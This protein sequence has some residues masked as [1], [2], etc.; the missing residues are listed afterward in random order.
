MLLTE[1]M[2]TV[3]RVAAAGGVAKERKT[4]LAV[5]SMP[6]VLLTSAKTT[7]G[8]VVAAG[9]VVKERLKDRWPC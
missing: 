5:L 1:R 7:V 8:R 4:P 6:V 9:C 3:G 2:N